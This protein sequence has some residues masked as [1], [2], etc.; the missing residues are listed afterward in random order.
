MLEIIVSQVQLLLTAQAIRVTQQVFPQ[1]DAAAE[2]AT[3]HYHSALEFH[4]PGGV[5]I[6][7]ED[8]G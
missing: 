6:S 1:L 8:H 2:R 7:L 5:H 4:T 3:K